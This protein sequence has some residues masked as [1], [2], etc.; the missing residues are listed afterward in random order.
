MAEAAAELLA[1]ALLLPP[2]AVLRDCGASCC[3]WLGPPPV[4]LLPASTCAL[5]PESMCASRL[6][7]KTSA[8]Q[9]GQWTAASFTSSDGPASPQHS[10]ESRWTNT[11]EFFKRTPQTGH[12]TILFCSSS[13]TGG[14]DGGRGGEAGGGGGRGGD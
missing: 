6:D 14:G 11:S 13:A 9:I 1:A 8:S 7:G 10:P 4:L 12:G 5:Q 3:N 2:A